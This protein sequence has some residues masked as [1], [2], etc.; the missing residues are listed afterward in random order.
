MHAAEE[1]QTV[2]KRNADFSSKR[3]VRP[4]S[5][6]FFV[7]LP[8]I[9]FAKTAG[10]RASR[11]ATESDVNFGTLPPAEEPAAPATFAPAGQ[12]ARSRS[13]KDLP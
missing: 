4:A 8:A 9:A 5:G 7:K 12:K 11:F 13:V 3:F 1:L 10:K 2:I 6:V